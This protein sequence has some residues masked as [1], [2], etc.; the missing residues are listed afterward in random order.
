MKCKRGD[1]E[2]NSQVVFGSSPENCTRYAGPIGKGNSWDLLDPNNSEGGVKITFTAGDEIEEK[3]N[4]QVIFELRCDEKAADLEFDGEGQKF[5]LSKQ[6]NTLKFKSKF[7]C[8]QLNLYQIWQFINEKKVIFASV[9]ILVGLFELI[10][11]NYLLVPTTYIISMAAV[12]VF[13]FIFMFQLV[14]PSG[15]RKIYFI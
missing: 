10:L 15:C 4:Y 7:A 8:A 3:K 12:V 5:D 9:L 13:V 2:V 1:N 6:I 11:G 14:L